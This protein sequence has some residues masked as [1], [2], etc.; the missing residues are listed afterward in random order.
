MS[1]TLEEQI[2]RIVESHGANFYDTETVTENDQTIYRVYITKEGGVDLDTCAEISNDISPLLDVHPPVSGNY[3][4]E[5]SSPGIERTLRKPSHF[6]NAVGERVKLKISGGGKVKGVLKEADESGMTLENKEGETR[7]E[8]S[9]I[10]KARTYF[11][12]ANQK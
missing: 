10:N 12:W 3:Y 6:Q 11:D 2:A 8:Y 5:V 9:Q 7:Y 1:S 4:L